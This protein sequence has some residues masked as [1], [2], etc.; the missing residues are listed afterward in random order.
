M[1]S[2]DIHGYI[3]RGVFHPLTESMGP[4]PMKP[5]SWLNLSIHAKFNTLLHKFGLKK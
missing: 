2:E 1:A 3:A 4:Y 5:E